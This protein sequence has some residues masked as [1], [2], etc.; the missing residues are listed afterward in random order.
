VR[1]AELADQLLERGLEVVL[2]GAPDEADLLSRIARRMHGRVLRLCGQTLDVSAALY[3]RCAL[4]VTVDSGAGH[5]AAAVGTRTVR[6]Y[7]PAPP[8]V[9]GPWPPSAGQ[10]AL[11]SDA[12]ACAPCGFLADPPC[13]ARS[14][15]A[16]M[17]ALHVDDVLDA[18]GAELRES[19]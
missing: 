7:G 5:L 4:V 16:C 13:G 1:W 6:L 18:I 10:I 17:L 14:S 11:M 9:F 12:L 8:T 3:A 19:L 2:F 15:P